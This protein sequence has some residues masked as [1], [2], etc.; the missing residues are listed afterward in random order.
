[1]KP[2][3]LVITALV[4]CSPVLAQDAAV[5]KAIQAQYEKEALGLAKKD[6]K[7]MLSINT[8]DYTTTDDKGKTTTMAELKDQITQL[9]GMMQSAKVATKIEKLTLKGDTATVIASDSSTVTLLNP[10]TKAKSVL[11][12]T[13]RN[14]DTW[15]KQKGTWLRQ[16]NK[17]LSHKD[18]VDGKPIGG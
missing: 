12:G 2:F 11:T 17:V 6:A 7:A 9:F 3:P 16:K 1:M 5:K 13:S 14:E 15:I 8:S 4:L 10:Q 18:L